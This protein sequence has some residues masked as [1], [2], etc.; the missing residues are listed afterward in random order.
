MTINLRVFAGLPSKN[1]KTQ[2]QIS[3][4]RCLTKKRAWFGFRGLR[5]RVKGGHLCSVLIY[6]I[7][8]DGKCEATL[9]KED[10]EHPKK[11]DGTPK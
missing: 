11:M 2:W 6:V 4:K 5:F 8:A 3:R 9:Q 10:E 1:S 7:L